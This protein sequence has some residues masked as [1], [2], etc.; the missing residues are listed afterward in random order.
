MTDEVEKMKERTLVS[1]CPGEENGWDTQLL[2][3]TGP[4]LT[5]DDRFLFMISDRGGA[6]NVIVR[7]LEAGT[8]TTLTHNRDGVMKS[9]VYFDGNP[10][11]GLSKASVCLDAERRVAYFIQ[12]NMICKVGMDGVVKNLAPVPSDRVTAFTHVSADGKFLR[13]PVD[14][15]TLKNMTCGETTGERLVVVNAKNVTMD[16]VPLSSRSGKAPAR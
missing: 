11:K 6:P 8:E 16:G 12:D 13:D 15:V 3:F 1:G 2:Y 7:D 4:S 10:G 14:G 9:Y 5:S